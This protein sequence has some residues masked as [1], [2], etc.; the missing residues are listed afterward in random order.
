MK[1][2]IS[3]ILVITLSISLFAGCA[4]KEDTNSQTGTQTSNADKTVE[5]KEAKEEPMVIEWLSYNP[6]AE[7]EEGAP[8]VEYIEEKFNVDMQVWFLPREGFDQAINVRIAGGDMPDIFKPKSGSL[9]NY[10][11]QGVAGEVPKETIKEY[12]PELYATYEELFPDGSNWIRTMYEGK[13]YGYHEIS[14]TGNF[15]SLVMWRK[16]WLEN[17]GYDKA[18]VTIDEFEEVLQKFADEDPDGNGKKDTYGMS[19]FAMNMVFGAYGV[20]H[21]SS[22]EWF[23]TNRLLKDGVPTFACIQPETKEALATLADWYAKGIIDPEFVTSEHTSGHWSESQAFYN[24]RIGLSGRAN[25]GHWYSNDKGEVERFKNLQANNP[26][27]EV[28][29]GLPPVGPNGHSGTNADGQVGATHMFTTKATSDPAKVQKIL[30]IANEPMKDYEHYLMTFK[31]IE[32]EHYKIEN[33]NG[34]DTFVGLIPEGIE[35]NTFGLGVFVPVTNPDFYAKVKPKQVEE[36]VQLTAGRTE[37]YIQPKV[38]STDAYSKYAPDLRRIAAEA[39]I[40]IVTGEKPI[41]YF[42]EFVETYLANGG[43]E[44]LD[45]MQTAYKSAMGME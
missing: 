23:G 31:G 43:Q 7:P 8:I 32:N 4:E 21:L 35:G 33:I 6:E 24:G 27:A 38:P 26:D 2:L 37:G 30:E 13:N 28:L 12:A 22:M 36:A 39:F 14:S 44:T 9:G 45:E 17:L 41:D 5:N 18:P 20:G 1:K 34:Y 16:D 40:S 3:I 19:D 29:F 42:D 10:V 11:K 15:P 25:P